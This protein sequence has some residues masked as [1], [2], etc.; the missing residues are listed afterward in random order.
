MYFPFGSRGQN[1]KS[2]V[3]E[4]TVVITWLKRSRLNWL[5]HLRLSLP[6]DE[7]CDEVDDRFWPILSKKS[8]VSSEAGS[9]LI[10]HFHLPSIGI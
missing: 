2:Q 6:R 10:K 7:Q 8:A 4:L 5:A 3:Q 1:R 9:V